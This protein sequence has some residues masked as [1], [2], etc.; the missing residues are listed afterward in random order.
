MLRL[1]VVLLGAR[2]AARP[3]AG[4]CSVFTN[5]RADG[6][7][8]D[9]WADLRSLVAS[10]ARAKVRTCVITDAPEASA[11]DALGAA[12]NDVYPAPAMASV[13]ATF[14]DLLGRAWAVPLTN[15]AARA[16]DR[17]LVA[18][19]ARILAFADP[20]YATTLFLDDDAYAC[21]GPALAAALAAPPPGPTVRLAER[22]LAQGEI[23]DAAYA[24][25]LAR[26][27]A[28][29]ACA[30]SADASDGA[31]ALACADGG[32]AAADACAGFT[33]APPDIQGGAV[34]VVRSRASAAWAAALRDAYVE[35]WAASNKTKFLGRDQP[36]HDAIAARFCRSS[37]LGA[38]PT[39]FNVKLSLHR[40]LANFAPVRHVLLGPALVLHYKGPKEATGPALCAA[41]HGDGVR[42]VLN[43]TTHLLDRGADAASALRVV[44]SVSIR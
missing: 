12:L 34:Y 5:V 2:A 1:L 39:T 14:A 40:T 22:W 11:R 17:T 8:G 25:A 37:V 20:P 32:D 7:G 4:A 21:P 16:V 26:L 3:A 10:L 30:A 23:F 9:P 33:R 6:R 42:T 29:A 43:A 18:R 13:R 35:Y 24:P 31:G 36:A 19:L 38:L 28:A 41:L 15:K 44:D 27:R